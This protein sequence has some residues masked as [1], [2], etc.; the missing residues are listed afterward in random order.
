MGTSATWGYLCIQENVSR[1]NFNIHHFGE[2]PLLQ[3]HKAVAFVTMGLSLCDT[4]VFLMT[5]NVVLPFGTEGVMMQLYFSVQINKTAG[6]QQ[7]H[8]LPKSPAPLTVI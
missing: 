8:E 2:N 7:G 6:P 1:S 4:E 3:N 5:K